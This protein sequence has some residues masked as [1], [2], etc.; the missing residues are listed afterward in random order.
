M[1]KKFVWVG[2]ILCLLV[3]V[4]GLALYFSFDSQQ[5]GRN[6]LTRA[7]EASGVALEA[8]S[9]R[10]GIFRGVELTGVSAAGKRGDDE[11]EVTVDRLRFQHRLVSLLSG[12]IVVERVLLEGL[13]VELTT[14]EGAG[15]AEGESERDPPPSRE[16]PGLRLEVREIAVRNG[17]VRIRKRGADGTLRENLR[18]D[19]LDLTVRELVFDPEADTPV[20]RFSGRGQMRVVEALAGT[21]PIRNIRGTAL[22]G[23]GVLN[24]TGLAL[25]TDYGDLT[26]DLR[27]DFNPSPFTYEVTAAGEPLNV[28][29]MVG[30]SGGGSLGPGELH[31]RANGRGSDPADLVGEGNLQLAPGT[32]PEHPVLARAESVLGLSGLAGGPYSATEAVFRIADKRVAIQGF[33]L[34]TPQMGLSLDG[35]ADLDGPMEF[36]L[37]M[38]VSRRGLTIEQVPASVLDALADAEGWILIPLKVTGTREQPS[39][40]PDTEALLSQAGRRF[41]DRFGDRLRESPLRRLVPR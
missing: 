7:G 27:V 28:N 22:F 12:N 1:V 36:D 9:I 17:F 4:G 32:V 15:S 37:G 20:R 34:S 40:S 8:E 31:F 21:M 25:S 19:G 18:L 14:F 30:A 16:L 5:L 13:K 24:A 23:K 35:W 41:L 11:Y 29:R 39:V 38:R 3:I 2:A 26:A 6:L 10:L 33:S